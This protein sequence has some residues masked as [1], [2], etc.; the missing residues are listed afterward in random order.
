[1]RDD[2]AK[3]AI[4]AILSRA[5]AA[6]TPVALANVP[7]ERRRELSGWRHQLLQQPD[8]RDASRTIDPNSTG[9]TAHSHRTIWS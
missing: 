3:T 2:Q 7:S 8:R 5:I 1:M 6:C 4:R 9:A